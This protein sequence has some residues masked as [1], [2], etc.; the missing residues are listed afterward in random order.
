M[1]VVIMSFCLTFLSEAQARTGG[2]TEARLLSKSSSAQTIL[3]NIGDLEQVKTGDY[4]VLMRRVRAQDVMAFRIIPIAK[5]RVVRTGRNRSIWFLY[6]IPD[7]S[8]LVLRDT[9]LI[10]TES[11]SISGRRELENT[12]LNVVDEKQDLPSNFAAKNEGDKNLLALRKKEYTSVRETHKLG[13]APEKDGVLYDASMYVTEGKNGEMKF[14]RA[15]WRSPYEKDFAKQK[16]LETFEKIVSVY[17]ERV[18][19]PLFNYGDFYWRHFRSESGQ[20]SAMRSYQNTYDQLLEEEN[21]SLTKEAAQ[22]RELLEKGQ[23][24]SAEYSDE[25]LAAM[26][27]KIGIVYEQ[28]RRRTIAT[29]LYNWQLMGSLGLNMLD[30]ENRADQENASKAKWNFELGGEWFPVPRAESLQKFSLW[31][32][33]RYVRDGVSVGQLNAQSTEY[34]LA[35]GG[36]WHMLH[37]PFMFDRNIPFIS[38]GFRTGVNRLATTGEEANYD[39]NSFPTIVAGIK[40]NFRSGMGLRV[41]VGFEKLQLEQTKSNNLNA[42]LPQREDIVEARLNLGLTKFY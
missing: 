32:F 28:D 35:V 31:S 23:A 33:V 39:M 37:S 12:R 20:L 25:E 42:V 21:K 17:L 30:N 8:Q 40:Y 36:T 10:T 4:A 6:D 24:W 41:G 16:R 11:M 26:M 29:K 34:S 7:K 1:W 9:Y 2:V 19:D 18:N 38:V 27:N 3:L 14:P 13:E 22:Y 15:L 5:G